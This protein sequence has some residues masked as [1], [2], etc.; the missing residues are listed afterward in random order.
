MDKSYNP[1]AFEMR[2]MDFRQQSGVYPIDDNALPTGHTERAASV[3]RRYKTESKLDLAS[4][5]KRVQLGTSD[6]VLATALVMVCADLVLVAR[7]NRCAG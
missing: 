3:V 7:R 1:A 5:I 2:W 4:V 6:A